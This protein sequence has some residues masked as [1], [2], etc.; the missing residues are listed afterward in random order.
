MKVFSKTDIGKKRTEN[1]DKVWAGKLCDNAAA[2]I[3][4]DGMGGENAGSFASQTTANFIAE[5]I[6]ANFR[7]D[8]NRNSVR[9]LLITSVT[10]ANTVIFDKALKEPSMKGMGTTC[11]CAIVIDSRAYIINV[12]DSRAY[13]I[14]GNTI[15]QIT[16]DHTYVRT[17]VEDGTIT[18]DEIK[19]HPQ[20]HCLIQAVG[21]E[22][23]V[24]PD[25]FELDLSENS[26]LLLC[27]DGLHG[28]GAD[29]DIATIVLAN[30]LSKICGKLVDYSLG[31]GGKDNVT[32]SIIALGGF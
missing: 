20:R 24:T 25:Y 1:Q 28:Y 27:S 29:E 32:V 3:L 31:K 22:P 26:I 5:R 11:V 15:Q 9:N 2:I 14:T 8:M 19:I 10:A 6:A 7:P 4:C 13:H 30:P 16:K 21:A 18:E 12:G 17:L 23:F